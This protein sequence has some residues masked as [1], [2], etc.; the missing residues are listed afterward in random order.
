[1]FG[2]IVERNRVNREGPGPGPCLVWALVRALVPVLVWA[3]VQVRALVWDLVLVLVLVRVR[4]LV[5]V[6]V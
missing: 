5:R 2:I 6:R 3:L 4:A 1:M